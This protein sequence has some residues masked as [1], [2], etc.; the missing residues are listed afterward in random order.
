MGHCKQ[1]QMCY[2]RDRSEKVSSVPRNEINPRPQRRERKGQT[3]GN[4]QMQ[5]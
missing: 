3:N 1:T 4:R 5:L 2:H